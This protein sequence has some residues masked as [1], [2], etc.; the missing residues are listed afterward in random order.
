M[1]AGLIALIAGL[2]LAAPAHA[3]EIYSAYTDID[4]DQGCAPFAGS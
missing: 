3:Q 1:K 2:V 4:L